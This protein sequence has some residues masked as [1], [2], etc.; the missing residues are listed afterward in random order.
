MPS[1][2]IRDSQPAVEL[3]VKVEFVAGSRN[4]YILFGGISGGL[5]MPPFE[6]YSAAGVLDSSKIFVRDMA[7]AWYQWGLPGIGS[8]VF[9][10]SEWLAA[11][12]DESGAGDDVC[13]VGNSMGGFAA[14]LFSAML[15]R[16]RAVAFAPQT[17]VG[18]ELRAAHGDRRWARQIELLHGRPQAREILDLAPFIRAGHPSIRADIY[19]ADDNR[20]DVVHA[21]QLAEFDNVRIHRFVGGGHN[22]VRVLRDEGK[23]KGI[24]SGL[25]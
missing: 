3:P 12:V 8:D 4:L 5:A 18:R 19:V 17:F 2:P 11:K 21:D 13:F 6:F 16:G 25:P 9:A 10:I 7:Q 15:R 24:L 23:L 14:L 22:L 20:L 1:V